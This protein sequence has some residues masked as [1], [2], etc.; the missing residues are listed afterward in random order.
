[1]FVDGEELQQVATGTTPASGQFGLVSSGDRRVVLGDN[2][3]GHVV[4]V[5]TR[6]NWIITQSNNVTVQG[7]SMRHAGTSAVAG[8]TSNNGYSNWT[9]KNSTLAYAHAADVMLAGG[10][11][12]RV[13]GNDICR[14]GLNGISRTGVSQGG[15]IQGNK[16]HRQPDC[17]NRV[18]PRVGRRR[19]QSDRN[20]ELR[21]RQ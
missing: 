4:E 20:A 6:P 3:S 10:T 9:L 16:I 7:M 1:V 2:P 19:C 8:P 18:Q 14:A 12:V 13:L 21:H 17:R 5:T 11:N 15:L